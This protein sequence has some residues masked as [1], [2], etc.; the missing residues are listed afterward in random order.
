VS[1]D[2]LLTLLLVLIGDRLFYGH[3]IWKYLKTEAEDNDEA[4][5]FINISLA[6]K[7]KDINAGLDSAFAIDSLILNG[8]RTKRYRTITK[9]PP[10]FQIY[11]QRQDFDQT[12]QDTVINKH[13]I[14]L[15]NV[16]YLDRFMTLSSPELQSLREKSWKIDNALEKLEAKRIHL[17]ATPLGI[18]GPDLLDAT[19]Q[20]LSAHGE[21][22]SANTA[23]LED[24]KAQSATRRVDIERLSQR[25]TQ[26][27]DDKAQLFSAHQQHAYRLAA[28]FVHRGQGGSRGGHYWVYVCDFKTGVWRRYEDRE[29][30]VVADE[31]EIFAES[32]PESQ[33]A[34]YFCVYVADGE[35]ESMV[36]AVYRI[37]PQEPI[38]TQMEDVQNVLRGPEE[39]EKEE[40]EAVDVDMA[41]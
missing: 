36:D 29:V 25:I 33:G 19:Y 27:K 5:S 2:R 8:N 3:F 26:L 7:P 13:H 34:P 10:V 23:I 16:I 39:E 32:D 11:L 21:E 38:D 40:K 20:F 4:F 37:K 30:R 22:I 15:N 31:Q 18:D 6:G 41:E 35:K 17:Q 24:L 9:L 1:E 14:Q 28:V 12:R